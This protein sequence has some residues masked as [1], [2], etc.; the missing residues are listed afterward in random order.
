VEV[1]LADQDSLVKA[2]RNVVIDHLRIDVLF[3]NA[4]VL[5]DGHHVSRHQNEL[6]FQV[7]ALAPYML[8]RLLRPALAAAPG[9]RVM[10]V[11]SGSI[12][13][14]GRLRIDELRNPRTRRKLVGP[15]AQSKLALT[16]LT[17]ALA[18]D[19]GRDGII[20]RSADPG[21]TKTR[22][23]RGAGMPRFLRWLQPLFFQDPSLAAERMIDALLDPQFGAR[24]GVYI[25]RSKVRVPPADATNSDVQRRLLVLCE[26]L[27]TV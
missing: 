14:T 8:M 16:T 9:G 7:N 17:S 13:S 4:G 15:Y 2:A 1:D 12:A 21:G 6:H 11:S 26:S 20:L 22:M 18:E 19:F 27:A 23:T 10:N 25:A 5:L 3:N 24:S